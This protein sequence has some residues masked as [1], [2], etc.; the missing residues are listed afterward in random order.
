MAYIHIIRLWK[1]ASC[2][3]HTGTV[4]FP[5]AWDIHLHPIIWDEFNLERI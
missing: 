5:I 1:A 3:L 4:E 2:L